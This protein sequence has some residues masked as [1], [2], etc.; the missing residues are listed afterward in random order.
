LNR[1][2]G[3]ESDRVDPLQSAFQF[4]RDLECVAFQLDARHDARM[5]EAED[6]CDESPGGRVHEIIGLDAGQHE[7]VGQRAD[8]RR[9]EARDLADVVRGG[10]VEGDSGDLVG[11]FRKRLAKHLL[12][13][14]RARGQCDDTSAGFLL[15]AHC[16]LKGVLVC[17][18][19]LVI[20]GVALDVFPIRR[21]LELQVWVRDLLEA[22]DD[23]QGHGARP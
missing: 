23:V 8:C 22:H 1:E 9:E 13:A 18:V 3:G 14:L 20:E 11:S 10:L 17:A 6:P 5:G 19:Q 4:A 12:G 2:H 7:V 15:E 21:N 16:L